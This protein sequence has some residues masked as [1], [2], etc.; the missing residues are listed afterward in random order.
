LGFQGCIVDR[1]QDF[2]RQR[3]FGHGRKIVPE[4]QTYKQRMGWTFPWASSLGGDF[5]FDF[6]VSLTEQQQR[7]GGVEYNYRREAVLERRAGGSLIALLLWL[8]AMG[9]RI[10]T[11][12]TFPVPRAR[13]RVLRAS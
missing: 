1:R 9:A 4:L 2:G 13:T 10:T 6:N 3:T 12:A 7:E 8:Y 5:N 11:H